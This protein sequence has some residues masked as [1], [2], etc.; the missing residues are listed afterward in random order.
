MGRG[1]AGVQRPDLGLALLFLRYV[2][3]MTQADLAQ[4]ARSTKANVS[5]YESGKSQPER[6]TL[7]RLLRALDFPLSALEDAIAL[8]VRLRGTARL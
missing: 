5:L 6:R 3:G 1:S 7:R 8:I 4:A 2:R